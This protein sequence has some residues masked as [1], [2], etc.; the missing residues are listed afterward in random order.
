MSPSWADVLTGLVAAHDLTAEQA[1]WAMNEI[2]TG[3]A[4]SAQI[5]G[6]L[7]ALQA[8]G[9]TAA[10]IGG[11]I[12]G[13]LDQARP[14]ELHATDAVDIV[15]T[16][17]DRANTVNVSTMAAMVA[18]AAGAAVIKHGNRAASSACGTADCLEALGV[19]LD[20]APHRQP[21]VFEATGIVFLFAAL[22]H[23]SLRH[24][25][26]PR[27]ELG[28]RTPFNVL[29][30]LANPARPAAAALGVA[31]AA[32]ATLMADVLAARGTRGVVFHGADGLD[33]LTTTSASQ[34]WLVV[35]GQV[36][37]TRLDPQD[38]GI[39]RAAPADLV[40]GDPRHNAQIVRDTFGGTPGPV[41][42]IVIL[43]AAAALLAA[44][45]PDPSLSLTDQ[46]V[47]QVE[48]AA[49]AIDSGAAA[50]LLTRWVEITSQIAARG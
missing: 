7:V 37:P 30:P 43:N 24:A 6:F 38:L 12:T 10:E 20:L 11:L 40:G 23:P 34:V 45:G 3:E 22:Y 5:A 9:P 14:I 32:T 1:S 25:A 46:F 44:A 48:R 4:T 50:S 8:K 49:A 36:H 42:D 41:R 47:P 13:M 39:P 2:L 15:G 35:D 16:G 27:R 28:I 33:E 19:V 31:D 29:G 18:A 21:E 26:V 17:G